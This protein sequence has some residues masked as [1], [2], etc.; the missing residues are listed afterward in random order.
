MISR[1]FTITTSGTVISPNPIRIGDIRTFDSSGEK[2]VIVAYD[3]TG[4]L[5]KL[6]RLSDD[7]IFFW[8]WE[9]YARF[10]SPT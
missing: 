4:R 7:G 3:P 10:T 8:G 9:N 6:R 2:H 5:V 1:N